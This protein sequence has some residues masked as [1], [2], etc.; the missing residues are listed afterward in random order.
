MRN[1]WPWSQPRSTRRWSWLSCSMPS[2][3]T[4]S[5]RLWARP[6]MAVTS[7]VLPASR[8]DQRIDERLVDLEDVDGEALEVAEGGVA[9][10]EV[11]DGDADAHLPE[12]G[13]GQGRPLGVLH[14][15]ALGDL[16][17]QLAGDRCRSGP[18]PFGPRRP[19]G[20]R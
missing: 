7:A 10:P 8:L 2:A 1:P 13:Q 3:M 6:M 16:E 4:S 18:G 17:D 12:L 19:G 15:D 5:P 20:A 14:Q 11:V 9:G